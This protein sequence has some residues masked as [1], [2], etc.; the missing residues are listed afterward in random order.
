MNSLYCT[1]DAWIGGRIRTDLKLSKPI[2][3]ADGSVTA[4]SISFESDPNTGFYRSADGVIGVTSNGVNIMNVGGGGIQISG[5]LTTGVGDLVLNP[6]GASVDFSGHSLI[7]IGGFSFGSGLPDHVIIND[8]AGI[9]S[10]EPQ[11]APL[12]GGLGID[13]SSSTGVAKVSAGT[14]TVGLITDGDFGT[15]NNLTVTQLT[16]TGIVS[17]AGMTINPTGTLT[18]S[19]TELY[20]TGG[21]SIHQTLV[22]GESS[23]T[24]VSKITSVSATP[25]TLFDLV[26]TSGTNGTSYTIRGMVTLASAPAESGSFTFVIKGK[27]LLGTASVSTLIQ[28]GSILDGT[29]ST[30][31]ITADVAGS[32][33]R[34]RA[35]GVAATTILWMGRFDVVSQEF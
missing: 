12:R 1:G 9:V 13:T 22:S 14:W 21:A 27:N 29:L 5:E 25:V 24:H 11:L 33:I 8:G 6:A 18:L 23:S 32:S 7:N 30:T 15:I 2:L 35:H 16:A 28:N 19:P 20:I 31:I 4:P 17:P 3:Y 10:S 34:I 26:T